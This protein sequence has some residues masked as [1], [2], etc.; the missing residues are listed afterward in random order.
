[1]RIKKWEAIDKHEMALME[2]ER[3]RWREVL[4]HLTVIVQSLAV[5]D[6]ALMGHTETLYSPSNGHFLKEVVL[7]AQFY[8]DMK[9][10]LNHVQK[11]TLSHT[12]SYLGL[13]NTKLT[14]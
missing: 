12:T 2:L 10:H 8:P 5:R 4:T 3:T 6:L 7:M 1:M 9:E 14:H 13:P 11:G